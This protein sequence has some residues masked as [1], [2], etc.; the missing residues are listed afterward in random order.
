MTK[1]EEV[2]QNILNNQLTS[3]CDYKGQSNA[4]SIN[5]TENVVSKERQIK[6]KIEGSTV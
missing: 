6:D 3:L 5:T 2:R 4:Q 1:K